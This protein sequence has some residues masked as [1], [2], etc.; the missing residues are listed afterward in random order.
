MRD[1]EEPSK[2]HIK[3]RLETNLRQFLLTSL[4]ALQSDARVLVIVL[5]TEA[6]FIGGHQVVFVGC[7]KNTNVGHMITCLSIYIGHHL[8]FQSPLDHLGGKR[9]ANYIAKM[10]HRILEFCMCEPFSC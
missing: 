3:I 1:E 8:W 7:F 5:E 10:L 2:H 6:M 9:R 4:K